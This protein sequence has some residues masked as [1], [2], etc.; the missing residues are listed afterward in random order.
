MGTSVTAV[1]DP[2][3][4]MHFA[5]AGRQGKF[6]VDREP[7]PPAKQ[8]QRPVPGIRDCAPA[9]QCAPRSRTP[10]CRKAAAPREGDSATGL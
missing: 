1:S 2:E 5:F 10:S 8:V 7:C 3:K 4:S 6:V 9:P